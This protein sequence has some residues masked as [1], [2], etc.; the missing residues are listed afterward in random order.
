[1]STDV[2]IVIPCFNE[3]D[4]IGQC[5]DSF[6]QQTDGLTIEVLVIDGMSTDNT[7][8]SNPSKTKDLPWNHSNN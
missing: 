4:Y 5:I 2:S 7:R 3:Q 6:F 8:K 1:M